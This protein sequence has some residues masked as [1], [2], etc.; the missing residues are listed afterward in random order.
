MR[1]A[2]PHVPPFRASDADRERV[3]A[4]LR[5]SA[6]EGRLTHDS[7]VRRVDLAL[8]ARHTNALDEL[9]RDLPTT[10][11]GATARIREWSQ[12]LAVQ[13]TGGSGRLPPLHLPGPGRPV[14]VVGR[15][16][17]CDLVLADPTVSRRHALLRRFGDAWFVEDLGST[18]GTRVN[19][20]RIRT[21]TVVRPGDSVGFGGVA[22]RVR[23]AR[24]QMTEAGWAPA[25]RP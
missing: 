13:V 5:E 9:V 22:F 17:S 12:R 25:R 2:G 1:G 4:V 7:F 3:V 24:R 20:L 19:G 8:R 18:N 15:G 16:P 11:R 10:T 23:A 21:S 14:L 6:V